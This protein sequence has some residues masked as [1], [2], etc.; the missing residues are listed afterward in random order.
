VVYEDCPIGS[1]PEV[2]VM[3]NVDRVEHFK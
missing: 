1:T 2:W 3:P